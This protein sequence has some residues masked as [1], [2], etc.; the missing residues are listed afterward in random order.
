MLLCCHIKYD[1]DLLVRVMAL[2]LPERRKKAQGIRDEKTRAA[3]LSAG[4]L[5]KYG[6][7]QCGVLDVDIC[8]TEK[9]KPYLAGNDLYFSLSHSGEYA[10]CVID[11]K[12]IGVDIQKIVA[13]SQRAVSRF[14]T[15]EEL[16]YLNNSHDY[17]RD[18]IRLWALKESWLKATGKSAADMFNA[19]FTLRAD[20]TVD[21]PEGFEYRLY[22]R[23]P[24]YI[25]AVCQSK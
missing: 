5:L 22:E 12:V 1:P 16:Q 21:G 15:E 19:S 4:L 2:S 14:C 8:Y 9:G 13:V 3:S 24:D 17:Y 25:L 20:G 11:K 7:Q 23:I 18:V 10:A 6:L